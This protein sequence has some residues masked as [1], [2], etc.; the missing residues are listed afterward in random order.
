MPM[1]AIRLT[2]TLTSPGEA[3]YLQAALANR[4]VSNLAAMAKTMCAC[5][6]TTSLALKTSLAAAT[7]TAM[8]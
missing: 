7:K 1:R 4:V 2:G 5:W 6:A 8:T 3:G